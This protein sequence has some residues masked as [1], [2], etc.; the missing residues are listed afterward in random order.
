MGLSGLFGGPPKQDKPS[1]KISAIIEMLAPGVSKAQGTVAGWEQARG[2]LEGAQSAFQ[3]AGKHN[4]NDTSLFLDTVISAIDSGKKSLEIYAGD[5]ETFAQGPVEIDGIKDT[6]AQMK[7]TS[8]TKFI[9]D[10]PVAARPSD[11]TIDGNLDA[12]TKVEALLNNM[13]QRFPVPQRQATIP[14]PALGGA[15]L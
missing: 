2:V 9:D 14:A 15:H 7:K 13:A 1:I 10:I 3:A 8:G 4:N 12:L 11:K 5:R 6:L